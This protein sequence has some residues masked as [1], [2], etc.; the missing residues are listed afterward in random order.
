MSQTDRARRLPRLMDRDLPAHDSLEDED[1]LSGVQLSGNFAMAEYEAVALSECRVVGAAFTGSSLLRASLVDCVITDSDLSGAI[2]E[3]CHFDRVEFRHCRLS[4]V[5][6]QG[7]RLRDVAVLDCKADGGNFRMTVWER[8]ELLDSNLAESDFY[9][10]RLPS[11]R[12]EGCDLSGVEFSKCDLN[13]ARLHRSTLDGI[14]G[15]EALRGITIGSDQVIPTALALF[16]AFGI[17]VD[18]G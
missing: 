17:T 16:A 3:D 7:S 10:A 1:D 9:G 8:S 14:R 6:A 13:G 18:D 11:S 15:G 2:L 4:G 5:Q 12:I